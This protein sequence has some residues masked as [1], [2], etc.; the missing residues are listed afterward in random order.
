LSGNKTL[1]ENV[2]SGATSLLVLLLTN[3]THQLIHERTINLD[4]VESRANEFYY[5]IAYSSLSRQIPPQH[6]SG[7]INFIQPEET[8]YVTQAIE[9]IFQYIKEIQPIIAI[10]LFARVI[11]PKKAW[12]LIQKEYSP[13]YEL[14]NQKNDKVTECLL[15]IE[16]YSKSLL[17]EL[18]NQAKLILITSV[19]Y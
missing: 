7:L 17:T 11:T 8:I 15:T 9:I 3:S 1:T 2:K 18:V 16:E 4:D 5:N 10:R 19:E 12:I 6:L 13:V 14:L